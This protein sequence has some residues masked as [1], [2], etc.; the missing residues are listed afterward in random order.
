MTDNQWFIMTNILVSTLVFLSS[1]L[2][3]S[4][5]VGQSLLKICMICLKLGFV[6]CNLH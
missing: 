6:V 4:R 1:K 5:N 3:I 2:E